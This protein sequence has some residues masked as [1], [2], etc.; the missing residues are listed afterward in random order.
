MSDAYMGEIKAF[1]FPFAPRNFAL[2]NGATIAISQNNAL[3]ALLGTYYGGN[4]TTTFQLPNLQS[5]YP[6]G[7]GQGLGLSQYVIG[8]V[9]GVEN[10]T[11]LQ[12]NMPIHTHIAQTT[13]TPN[14]SG[15]SAST[16]IHG[17][18][19]PSATTAI[20]TGNLLTAG[21]TGGGSPV[22]IKPYAAPANG[23]DTTLASQMAVTTI[24]GVVTATAATTL[25]TAGGSIPFN[26]QSPY[27]VI[28]YCI[29]T[30]GIFPS[31]N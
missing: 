1:G 27:L 7:Q 22:A 12:N 14:S 18:T 29:A 19:S 15:L 30:V 31:R 23:T 20:P 24:S 5:R 11:L 25:Q 4:G 21:T 26:I 8:E 28:N 6:I 17:L 13:V 3:F 16:A 10:V 9:G 2:C